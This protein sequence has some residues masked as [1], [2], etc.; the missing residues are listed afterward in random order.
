MGNV[1]RQQ[2]EAILE[3]AVAARELAE[4]SRA[5]ATRYDKLGVLL[6]GIAGAGAA[7]EQAQNAADFLAHL[8]QPG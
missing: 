1:D 5:A 6:A 2:R 3:A 7:F 8:P 4:L